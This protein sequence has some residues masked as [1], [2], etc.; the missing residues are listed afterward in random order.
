MEMINKTYLA[1]F[2]QIFTIM[3]IALSLFS[4]FSH[5]VYAQGIDYQ[6]LAPIPLDSDLS[7][8]SETANTS[9]FIE[10][11]FR[12]IIA[13][14]GGLA[15]IMIM[16]GGFQYLTTESFS[17]KGEAKRT[18][19]NA[20]AGFLLAIS[21]WLI[22]NTVNPQLTTLNIGLAPQKL[23]DLPAGG[24]PGG[25]SGIPVTPPSGPGSL[26]LSHEQAKSQLEASGIVISGPI[27]LAGL[28]QVMID[29]LIG[30]KQQCSS[31]AVVVTSATGGDHASGVCSHGNG[32][33][34]DLR[35]TAEGTALTNYIKKT[36]T[37]QGTRSDGSPI[38]LAPTGA[39]YAQ[40]SNH[41]DVVRCN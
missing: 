38:Y 1:R 30:L 24:T 35:S 14:A 25:T 17:G 23:P 5:S 32:Y 20:L 11:M 26:A 2:L 34:V 13:L 29:E 12:L 4:V 18:I 22:L 8:V 3:V 19:E 41:W 39:L 40:E 6:L 31:C 15:V 37:P 16:F 21:A 33:K 7:N 9:T 28:R 10:G 36:Y 27:T